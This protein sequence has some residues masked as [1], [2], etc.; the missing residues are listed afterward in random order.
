MWQ[1]SPATFFYCAKQVPTPMKRPR[2]FVSIAS[3]RDSECPATISDLFAKARYPDRVFAGVLWQIVPELDMEFVGGKAPKGHLRTLLVHAGE[4]R[5]VCWAR[6]R[7][8]TELRKDEEYVLQIDSHMRFEAGWDERFISMLESCPSKKA[9]LSSYPVDYTPPDILGSKR[10]PVLVAREFLD[11]KVVRLGSRILSYE[12]RPEVPSPSAF[13]GAGCIFAPATAFEEVP[14][15]PYLY[16]IGEEISLAVRLWTAGWDLFTPND[17]LLYHDYS[18]VRG[19]TRH[20]SDQRDWSVMNQRSYSR[21]SFL[22]SGIGCPEVEALRELDRFGLGKLRSLF[23]YQEYSGIDFQA[24]VLGERALDGRFP[25]PASVETTARKSGLRHARQEQ[26][27]GQHDT[28]SGLASTAKQTR[29]L[30]RSLPVLL[31]QFQVRSLLDA[32]CGDSDLIVSIADGLDLYIGVDLL[33]EVIRCNIERLAYRPMMT[34][35][36]ADIARDKLP[37]CDAV[38]CREVLEYCTQSEQALI[39][40]NIARSGAKFL[41]APFSATAGNSGDPA[42]V[43]PSLDLTADPHRLPMP[44]AVVADSAGKSLGLWSI[45]SWSGDH[46]TK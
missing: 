20:W 39:L 41:I 21:L 5:G 12:D 14:Y 23:D 29:E 31:D 15:D 42:K 30:R 43:S 35:C 6:S 10:I 38:L 34:F 18:S 37:R 44:E 4:S 11:N 26:P 45:G 25:M 7:I 3:Y 22:L 2:I 32:G 9:I 36:V 17:V 28:R 40:R 13:V 1:A 8:L 27:A 19:R 16:F 33:E 24:R 46:R